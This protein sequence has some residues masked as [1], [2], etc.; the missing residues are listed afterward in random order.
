MMGGD[1]PSIC[2][3]HNPNGDSLHRERLASESGGFGVGVASGIG[4][5][6]ESDGATN[7]LVSVGTGIETR[8]VLANRRVGLRG[9]RRK[10]LWQIGDL[11]A[12]GV[13]ARQIAAHL[14]MSVSSVE[15]HLGLMHRQWAREYETNLPSI[16][17]QLDSR[18][19]NDEVNV[20]NRMNGLLRDGD[21]FSHTTFIRYQKL[22]LDILDKRMA[23]YNVRGDLPGDG[24]V[25]LHYTVY[26]F[27]RVVDEK[28]NPPAIDVKGS[29][30][31]ERGVIDIGGVPETPGYERLE[32]GGG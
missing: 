20:R 5:D 30:V 8:G 16:R 6:E 23:L 7:E 19:R 2:E 9:D 3:L 25:Q 1:Y 4:V 29:V 31:N 15:R 13:G 22:L 21:R 32:G 14:G 11:Y 24:G 28:G 26:N 17:G 27:E 10:T 12:N 18:L